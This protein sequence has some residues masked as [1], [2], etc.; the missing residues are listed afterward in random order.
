MDGQVSIGTKRGNEE[1][2]SLRAAIHDR[3]CLSEVAQVGVVHAVAHVDEAAFRI[4][5]TFS[6]ESAA[7]K[8]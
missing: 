2:D 1:E 5:F 8:R 3:I 7:W 6:R 4:G